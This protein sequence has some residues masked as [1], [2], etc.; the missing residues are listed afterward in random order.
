M[1]VQDEL[2]EALKNLMRR[3]DDCYGGPARSNDWKEQAE[4]RALL[5]RLAKP[6]LPKGLKVYGGVFDGQRYTIVAARSKAVA[7]KLFGISGYAMKTRGAEVAR[8]VEIRIAMSKPG[9]VFGVASWR[10]DEPDAYE[11]M[12]R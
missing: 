3:M 5:D 6:E 1:N 4:A 7:A 9:T 12:K 8:A 11:E 2:H 10:F